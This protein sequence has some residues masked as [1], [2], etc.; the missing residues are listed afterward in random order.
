MPC[1]TDVQVTL[2]FTYVES[3]PDGAPLYEIVSDENLEDRDA[4]V[5]LA[6][7]A[8]QVSPTLCFLYLW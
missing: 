3:Y 6:L 7:L 1:F 2:K 8:E 5:V 4:S